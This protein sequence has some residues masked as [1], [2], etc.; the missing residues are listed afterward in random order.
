MNIGNNVD[1]D[2]ERMR[3]IRQA[4][5][6]R[7]VDGLRQQ[8]RTCSAIANCIHE[9]F[10]SSSEDP[11]AAYPDA[12]DIDTHDPSTKAAPV[13]Y[14]WPEIEWRDNCPALTEPGVTYTESNFRVH[15]RQG[16]KT[17]VRLK[18][19]SMVRQLRAVKHGL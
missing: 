16:N 2:Q 15:I 9:M 5:L 11:R 1:E 14:T 6:N 17:Y 7:W 19:P 13:S 3:Q 12:F 10:Q 8:Q 18:T 4:I